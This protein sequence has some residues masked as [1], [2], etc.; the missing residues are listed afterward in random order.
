MIELLVPNFS[1]ECALL[2]D[3]APAGFVMAFNCKFG[4]EY[5]YSTFPQAWQDEY[6]QKKYLLLDPVMHWM[7]LQSG[8]TRW[9]EIRTPDI[10]DI[11]GKARKYGLNYGAAIVISVDDKFSFLSVSRNDREF[12]DAEISLLEMQFIRLGQKVFERPEISEEELHVLR[13]L[14]A[15]VSRKEI[16]H[17]AGVSESTVKNRIRSAQSTLGAKSTNQLVALAVR[18]NII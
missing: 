17:E 18:L 4:A 9:S 1:K 5:Y 11:L 12:T 16:A 15:G 8:K 3:V 14:A 6:V 10:R 13:G 2:E 7:R